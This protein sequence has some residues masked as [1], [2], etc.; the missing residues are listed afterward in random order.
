MPVGRDLLRD[1]WKQ[2]KIY[3]AKRGYRDRSTER[4]LAAGTD[5][6]RGTWLQGQTY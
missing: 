6:L 4:H 5:I 2:E 1:T 3:R